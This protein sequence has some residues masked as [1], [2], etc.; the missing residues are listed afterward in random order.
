MVVVLTALRGAFSGS[1][2][3]GQANSDSFSDPLRTFMK[4]C[5][6]AWSW[7]EL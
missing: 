1:E 6:S 5:E 2:G 7:M 3:P 4:Q